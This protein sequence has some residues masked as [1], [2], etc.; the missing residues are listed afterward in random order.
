M[1]LCV[2]SSTQVIPVE[3]RDVDDKSPRDSNEPKSKLNSN[4]DEVPGSKN[5]DMND[6]NS[7]FSSQTKS[8]FNSIQPNK[9]SYSVDDKRDEIEK[10]KEYIYG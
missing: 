5:H 7:L 1:G 8:K 3:K 9:K 4:K 10:K 6:K 2:S